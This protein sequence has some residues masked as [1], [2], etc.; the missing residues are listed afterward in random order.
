MRTL[1]VSVILSATLF[2]GQAGSAAESDH[3]HWGT[4]AVV[5]FCCDFT[6]YPPIGNVE[7]SQQTCDYS[8]FAD[9]RPHL[10]LL[11]P[12]RSRFSMQF[13]LPQ[14][15]K[16]AFLEVV[17]LASL[18]PEGKGESPI[19]ITANGKTVV[20]DWNVG[21]TGKTTFC[22]TRWPIGDKLESGRNQIQ[23][24]AGDLRTHYW[25]RRVR[26]YV[27]FDHPV[28]VFFPVS[29]VEHALF[30]E[31]RFSQC[32]YN[33]LAT[34]LDRFY[35]VEP[36]TGDREAYEKRTFVAPLEKF[37][38]GG[39]FGWAPWTSYMVQSG[40]IRWNGRLVNGLK[41]QRFALR[42][43]AIP[44]ARG[45]EMIVRYQSGERAG[46]EKRLLSRL[47]KGPVI[48]WTPYAAAQ[49]RGRNAWRHVRAVDPKTDAVRFRANTTHSVVV[50]LEGEKIKVYDNSWPGGIWG[51][52]PQT[53][54]ATAAA[55][56]G[57]V[58]LDRGK[59]KTLRGKGFSGIDDDQYNVVFWHNF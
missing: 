18:G 48:L 1:A 6:H 12:R 15:P 2:P 54:V 33:A 39:Y 53:V 57:S 46:L 3:S 50:N 36:W 13:S 47:K 16:A 8:I 59:G 10:R 25:L 34:V 38:L 55:M 49:D 32:S 41:A 40:T 29:R 44:Q 17:H 37:D 22:E 7:I 20:E 43:K 19:S 52:E 11:Q 14:A 58:R 9:Q 45:E 31:G 5:V 24:Q 30:W 56:A 21:K 27:R 26:L 4:G 35:G 28:S 51:V 23:W 42:T